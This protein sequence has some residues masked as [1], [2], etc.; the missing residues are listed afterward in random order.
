LN[1]KCK[2]LKTV[3]H[4][5]KPRKSDILVRP[6]FSKRPIPRRRKEIGKLQP[7]G[8]PQ[9]VDATAGVLLGSAAAGPAGALIGLSAATARAVTCMGAKTLETIRETAEDA[10]KAGGGNL[11]LKGCRH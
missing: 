10:R 2:K 7:K 1:R 9:E 8:A 5:I 11:K 3:E 4:T 6:Q